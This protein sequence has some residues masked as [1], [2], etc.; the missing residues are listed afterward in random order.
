M[1][2]VSSPYWNSPGNS[3]PSVV[4][5]AFSILLAAGSGS[6][7]SSSATSASSA[8][9]T[10]ALGVLIFAFFPILFQLEPSASISTGFSIRR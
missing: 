6:R 9:G 2:N 1:L 10:V 5:R 7:P 8:S 3:R 4:L